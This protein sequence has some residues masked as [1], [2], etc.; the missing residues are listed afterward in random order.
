MAEQESSKCLEQVEKQISDAKRMMK[1]NWESYVN[2]PFDM[3]RQHLAKADKLLIEARGLQ[4][5]D[6]EDSLSKLKLASS[7]ALDGYLCSLP[8]RTAE[9]RGVWYRAIE[10]SRED[11]SRT[12]DRMKAAGFNELYLETWLWGYTIFPSRTAVAKQ[13]QEQHPA[14]RGWDPLEAFIHE[15]EKRGIAV[16]AWLDGF[17]VGVDAKGGPVLR[18][19][20][21]WSALSRRQAD[22]KKPMPQQGT[23]YFWL[24]ITN[25]DVR[26]YVLHIVKEIITTY[27]VAGINLDFM[28][29]PHT[30]NNWEDCYCFSSYAREAFKREH[31]LDPYEI[32][33]DK[34]RE[35]WAT[36]MK[37]IE[38][39]EDEFVAELY[40]EIKR[41]SPNVIVSA[42]PE[43]GAESEKIGNWSQYVDVVIPQAYYDNAAEV[44]KSVQ[45]HQNVLA[46]GNL[47]YSGIYPMYAKLES[48]E[49][50]NQV[51][52]ARDMDKGTVIF[53]FG[54]A[55]FETIR[56]L[57]IGPWRNDAISTGMFPLLAIQALL[58]AIKTDV[59]QVYLPRHA[60]T[61]NAAMELINTV[62]LLLDNVQSDDMLAACRKC[63]L[64]ATEEETIRSTV[65]LQLTNTLTEI[66]ELLRYSQIKHV[67]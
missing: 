7:W 24:D 18:A 19:Y 20:P 67:K 33:A 15:G 35:L 34:H 10:R 9:A 4:F 52:A 28:R 3:A 55:T 17:M 12:L 26:D 42:A 59:V 48:Q 2:A 44:R 65:A 43:P 14:F 29:F 58:V 46:P 61:E 25:P 63:L 51:L 22:A 16:H 49:T 57:R 11:V 1:V 31:D 39:I 66:Q 32:H 54:Q 45:L 36:W 23:G 60:M 30:N 6:P 38:R 5:A 56:A 21:A 41:I 13:I 53:A 8:S 64:K 37:W 40:K 27:G 50:I 47:V 62:D